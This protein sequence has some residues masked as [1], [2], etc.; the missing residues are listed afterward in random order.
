MKTVMVSGHFDPFHDGHLS[1]IKQAIPHIY[2]KE[3]TETRSGL[4]ICIVSN[5]AQLLKKKGKVNITEGGRWEIVDLILTGLGVPHR[6]VVNVWDKGTT[7]VAEALREWRPHIF[8]RGGDKTLEDMPPEE[9]RVCDELGIQ[10]LHAKLEYDR[11]GSK[12][13]L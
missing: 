3:N 8:F 7:L 10:I 6:T 13:Q 12:M 2:K 4:L 1:Y 5:D 9:R 11:H